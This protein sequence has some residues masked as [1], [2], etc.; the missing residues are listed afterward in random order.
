MQLHGQWLHIQANESS[1][2]RTHT[3]WQRCTPHSSATT[4]T[5]DLWRPFQTITW[6]AWEGQSVTNPKGEPNSVTILRNSR[7]FTRFQII[8]CN[9]MK[10]KT[11]KQTKN[12]SDFEGILPCFIN[13]LLSGLGIHFKSAYKYNCG[14]PPMAQGWII[15]LWCRIHREVGSISGS[16]RSPGG[17]HGNSLQYSCLGKPMDW[18]AWWAT[19]HGIAKNG[20]QLS[21]WACMSQ[22]LA[23]GWTHPIPSH[24]YIL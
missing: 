13:W 19:V 4:K 8:L 6:W 23:H 22:S 16:G 20:T 11:N 7:I 14:L 1:W 9:W 15:L 5:D 3:P 2:P 10:R 18:G 17:R 24:A 21:N 12:S